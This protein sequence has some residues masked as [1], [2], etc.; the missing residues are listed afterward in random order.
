MA[1]R[2]GQRNGERPECLHPRFGVRTSVQKVQRG[3]NAARPKGWILAV[4]VHCEQCE[5]EFVFVGMPPGVRL[6]QPA[7]SDDGGEAHLP[8]VPVS[9]VQMPVDIEIARN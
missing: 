1:R 2:N 9:K 6:D 3:E 4:Q 7:V 8:I 5:E